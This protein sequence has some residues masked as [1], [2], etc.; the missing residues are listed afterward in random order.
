MEAIIIYF[1]AMI[2]TV[3]TV[4]EAIK[5]FA[6]TFFPGMKEWWYKPLAIFCTVAAGV[7]GTAMF[8]SPWDWMTFIIGTA[9][10]YFAQMGWD[11]GAAKPIIKALFF[12]DK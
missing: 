10:L 2:P 9:V 8:A 1:T 3:G 7:I 11:F 5:K 6:E 4:I 12:K